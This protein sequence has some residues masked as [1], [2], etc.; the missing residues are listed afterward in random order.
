MD[1]CRLLRRLGSVVAV[2]LALAAAAP[3]TAP[4]QTNNDQFGNWTW[5]GSGDLDA[6][7]DNTSYSF[8]SDENLVCVGFD[9]RGFSRTAWWVFVVSGRPV[10]ITTAGSDFDTILAAYTPDD[11]TFNNQVA[12]D[13]GN[14]NESITFPTVLDT[15]YYIQVGG[16]LPLKAGECGTPTVGHVHLLATTAPPA[17][18]T[19]SSAKELPTGVGVN[20]DNVGSSEEPGEAVSCAARGVDLGRTTWYVW[21]SPGAGTAT[22]TATGTLNE[23]LAA[24]KGTSASQL[25]CDSVQPP[26][27]ARVQIP[28][29]AGDYYVQAAGFGRHTPPTNED[30]DQ[31]STT[32]KA[33]FAPAPAPASAP[34]V[35]PSSGPVVQTPKQAVTASM[36]ST[37]YVVH[38]S[39]GYTVLRLIAS[40]VS[41]GTR[42]QVR[43]SGRSC[44][45]ATRTTTARKAYSRLTLGG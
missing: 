20:G 11:T 35:A 1:V 2:T 4:A 28:V 21:H 16:C 44:P 32:V 12:C 22:F 26:A 38:R 10:T 24:Y 43:C 8:D 15:V 33:E 17:N 41:A 36:G 40:R 5:L 19:R 25:S 13:D 23:V 34:S 42:I 3:A 7:V 6:T 29:E 45:F 9:Q 31:G 37:S 18:D 14:L 27:T 39:R 30:S